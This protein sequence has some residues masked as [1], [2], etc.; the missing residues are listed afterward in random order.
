[1]CGLPKEARLIFARMLES[2]IDGKK[3]QMVYD[4]KMMWL[5]MFILSQAAHRRERPWFWLNTD[6]SMQQFK[7]QQMVKFHINDT[8]VGADYHPNWEMLREYSQ[9]IRDTG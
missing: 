7:A 2:V 5:G 4:E 6:R 3:K 8:L 9:R 1:M